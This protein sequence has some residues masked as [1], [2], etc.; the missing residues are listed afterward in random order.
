MQEGK[1]FHVQA[2]E[3]SMGSSCLAPVILKNR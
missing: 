2:M 3:P 1:V